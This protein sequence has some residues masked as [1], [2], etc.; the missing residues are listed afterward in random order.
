MYK[1]RIMNGKKKKMVAQNRKNKC[2]YWTAKKAE[3][4]ETIK[5]N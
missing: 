3:L 2:F 5:I 1:E 4:L